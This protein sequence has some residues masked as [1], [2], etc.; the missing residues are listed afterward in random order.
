[1]AFISPLALGAQAMYNEFCHLTSRIRLLVFDQSSDAANEIAIWGVGAVGSASH[2][3]CEGQ[4][5]E[6]PTL[7]QI[8]EA[9]FPVC[10]LFSLHSPGREIP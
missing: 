2:W 3:Q 7:H 8:Q 10:L 1:M 9:D 6:S 4:G 5:F